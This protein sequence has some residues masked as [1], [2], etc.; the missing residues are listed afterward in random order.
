[1]PYLEFYEIDGYLFKIIIPTS[2]F[3]FKLLPIRSVKCNSYLF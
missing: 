3:G 1:M 2:N